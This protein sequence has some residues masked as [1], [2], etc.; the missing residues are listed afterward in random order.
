MYVLDSSAFINEYHTNSKTASI[1]LVREEL[2]DESAYRYDAME[3]SGMHIHI[4]GGETV[5]KIE[6]AAR[7]S[8]DLDELSETDIRLIAA[9]FELDGRLVTDDYAMQNVA[10]KLN[11]D[12]EVIARD[13]IAEQRDWKFQCQGCGREFDENKERCPICGSPLSRKNPSNA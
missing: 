3:G 1:P 7:E 2:E 8:G 13:G 9:T 10:D 11:V 4:P 5:E 6:R 12:V